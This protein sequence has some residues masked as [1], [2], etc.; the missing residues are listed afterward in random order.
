MQ[1]K[2]KEKKQIEG[3]LEKLQWYMDNRWVV[4]Y[5]IKLVHHIKISDQWH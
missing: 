5:Q 2:W 1:L 3:K 4:V